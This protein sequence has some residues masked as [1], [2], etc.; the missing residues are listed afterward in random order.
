MTHAESNQTISNLILQVVPFA[1]AQSAIRSIRYQVFHVE[2]GVALDID[3]DGLD[4]ASMHVVAYQADQ[5]V[6]TTRIRMLTDR[7]A[8]IERVAVL[9]VHRG[10]GLGKMLMTTAV[11][12]L[13]QQA[14]PE[15]KLNAQMQVKAFY[16]K[17][18]FVPYG[19]PFD[20]AG[21]LHIEMRRS[22]Q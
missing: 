14:I 12:Y 5:A 18:G 3:F 19:E 13:D 17:L 15:I 1:A 16:E 20:E 6:G 8:K 21:I 10:R 2:Q 9:S 7:L 4:E 11:D 22:L